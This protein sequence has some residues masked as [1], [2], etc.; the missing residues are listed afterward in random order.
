MN[1]IPLEVW[2]RAAV[3]LFFANFM[4]GLIAMIFVAKT[5]NIGLLWMGGTAS[6]F[7]LFWLVRYIGNRQQRSGFLTPHVHQR[8]AA[9]RNIKKG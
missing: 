5:N 4:F 7:I 3:I 8:D 2:A 9:M 6:G 1:K